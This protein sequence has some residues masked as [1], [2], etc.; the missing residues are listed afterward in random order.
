MI[1]Q[2][3]VD[4]TAAV[5]DIMV[6]C[7][8]I[9]GVVI[10]AGDYFWMNRSGTCKVLVAE[11]QTAGVA[12]TS[13]STTGTLSAWT[14]QDAAPANSNVI[15]LANSSGSAVAPTLAYKD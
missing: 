3:T 11:S 12:L 14:T 10:P 9:A 7:N 6:G 15:L 4:M 1:G 2:D 13:T 5:G 8:D